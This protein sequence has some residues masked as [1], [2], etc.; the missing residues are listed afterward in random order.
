MTGILSRINSQLVYLQSKD[1]TRRLRPPRGYD[2]CSN[3]YFCL[4]H[5]PEIGAAVKDG[6]I[7]YGYGSTSS[8]FIRG[9]RDIYER[10]ESAFAQFLHAEDAL[11]F[12]SGYAANIGVLTALIQK[13]DLVFSDELNH[14]SL[15]D[16]LRL[17]GAQ[18]I[19]FP[20]LDI[21]YV[22]KK[23]SLLPKDTPKFL[24][25]ESLFSMNGDIA[26]LDRY[27]ELCKEH[28]LGLLVDEAHA[29]G[30]YGPHG[31][32]LIEYFNIR[33]QVLCSMAGLGKAFC[34]LGAVV[35][36]PEAVIELVLQ[37]AR[38]L[39]YTTALPPA[40]LCGIEQALKLI[41]QGHAMREQLFATINLL[42]QSLPYEH[43]GRVIPSPIVPIF[44]GDNHKALSLAQKLEEAGFDIR[45]IRPPTVPAGSARLRITANISHTKALIA[46]L[47]KLL[48]ELL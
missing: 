9:E 18:I 5:N 37:K 46:A 47:A 26:P 38:T 15:I 39:M 12:S 21:D 31:S 14:A 30:I 22:H 3:D 1:L 20:H 32:G 4:S 8:R 36:G 2:F 17:S 40:A 33:E 28:E 10:L 25:S 41:S 45:A 19:I 24:V 43:L 6:I 16:G 34:C 13:D 23:L 44:L 7:K 27:A 11:L 35:A 48:G 29:I 42:T